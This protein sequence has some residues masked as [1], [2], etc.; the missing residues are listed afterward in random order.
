M[1]A[2]CRPCGDLQDTHWHDGL[3]ASHLVEDAAAVHS[4]RNL[5]RVRSARFLHYQ[6][7][8]RESVRGIG[9]ADLGFI[10]FGSWRA[11]FSLIPTKHPGGHDM[12]PTRGWK[13]KTM[14]NG[15]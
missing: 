2:Q 10:S 12:R 3:E 15:T 5:Q 11:S 1:P 8:E 13:G 9:V 6:G 4:Q 7:R 14:L